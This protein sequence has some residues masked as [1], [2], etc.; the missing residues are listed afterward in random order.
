MFRP[1]N[2]TSIAAWTFGSLAGNEAYY[3]TKGGSRRSTSRKASCPPSISRINRKLEKLSDEI[4]RLAGDF[5]LGVRTAEKGKIE[6][7]PIVRIIFYSEWF[8]T[9]KET[10]KAETRNAYE[11]SVAAGYVWDASAIKNAEASIDSVTDYLNE[12]INGVNKLIV[13]MPGLTKQE[14]QMIF[15][16]MKER[17]S[18]C[19]VDDS[20][21]KLVDSNSGRLSIKGKTEE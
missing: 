8:Q 1:Y 17:Q 5:C 13:D 15:S 2:L 9:R 11:E 10:I 21:Y 12:I 3:R 18:T 4:N 6:L 16:A 20:T 14:H 19:R 7:T